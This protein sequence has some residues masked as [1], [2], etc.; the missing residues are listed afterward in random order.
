MK[1]NPPDHTSRQNKPKLKRW[2]RLSLLLIFVVF[3]TWRFI[4][5]M[6]IFKVEDRFALPIKVEIP[7]GIDSV[8]AKECG[9]CHKEIYAE[10]SESMH[11]KAWTDPYFQVDYVYDDSKQICLNC[12]TPLENQQ[13][14]LVL[15]FNDRARVDPILEPNPDFDPDLR[16][17]GMTCAVCHVK[18]ARIVGPFETDDAPHPVT[19]DPEMTSG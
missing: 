16:D 12:H 11:A 15:G 7:E 2:L 4:R 10:W 6:N 5:P 9:G 3:M 1:A 13:E 17:E 19:V 18:N 14:N 8:S